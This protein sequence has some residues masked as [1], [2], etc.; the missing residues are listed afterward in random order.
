[1]NHCIFCGPTE[2]KITGE[3]LWGQW[4][5]RVFRQRGHRKYSARRHRT[6]SDPRRKDKDNRWISNDINIFVKDVCRTC[7]DNTLSELENDVIKPLLE[8]LSAGIPHNLSIDDQFSLTAW[9]MRF[10]MV[11]EFADEKEQPKYFTQ[12]EREQFIS[13]FTLPLPTHTWAWLAEYRGR[14][15]I[16]SAQR[17][18]IALR[19]SPDD[20]P[21]LVMTG[22]AGRLVFQLLSRRWNKSP[23]A[24]LRRMTPIVKMWSPA[25]IRIWPEQP[26][27]ISWPPRKYLADDSIQ[28]FI[29]RWSSL[30]P[31]N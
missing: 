13:E 3:H 28:A 1:M 5:S 10:A 11:Y 26:R 29:D 16:I 15:P 18:L 30:A 24:E 27:G 22:V 25:V 6:T 23:R 7:N 12:S 31:T 9:I 14:V 4:V 2:A 8:P 19:P 17:A 20:E 21:F